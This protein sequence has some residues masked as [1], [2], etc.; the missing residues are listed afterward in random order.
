MITEK[1]TSSPRVSMS[2]R[3]GG[4]TGSCEKFSKAGVERGPQQRLD[5]E[6]PCMT[7]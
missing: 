4:S 2:N 3:L 6:G 5:Y 1:R 7:H